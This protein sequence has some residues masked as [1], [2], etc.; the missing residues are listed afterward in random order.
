[1]HLSEKRSTCTCYKKVLKNTT[2]T[3]VLVNLLPVFLGPELQLSIQFRCLQH[4]NISV[5]DSQFSPPSSQWISVDIPV[6]IWH[7]Y[8]ITCIYSYTLYLDTWFWY[9]FSIISKPSSQLYKDLVNWNRTA[10]LHL[11]FIS[12]SLLLCNFIAF[13]I[14]NV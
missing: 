13:C 1:M 12:V 2:A 5:L 11:Y 7:H 4:T 14:R 3:L 8:T 9:L 6:H 10:L